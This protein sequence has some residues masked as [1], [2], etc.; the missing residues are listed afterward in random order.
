MSTARASGRLDGVGVLLTRARHQATALVTRLEEM[1]AQ[2]HAH[3]VIEIVPPQ[4]RPPCERP[5]RTCTRT[6]GSCSAAPTPCRPACWQGA[7]RGQ[8][9]AAAWL[10][11]ERP[12][13]THW[14]NTALPSTCCRASP[15]LRAW[16]RHW[17]NATTATWTAWW[18][19]SL[20]RAKDA[21]PCLASWDR[22]EPT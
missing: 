11:W 18:Y 21:M 7:A 5:W 19:S 17:W 14:R 1:G 3:P 12:R 15:P 22:A 9:A 4:T 16:P 20:A 6:T 2:V 8:Q 13:R 10:Q